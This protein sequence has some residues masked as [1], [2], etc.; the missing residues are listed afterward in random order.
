MVSERFMLSTVVFYLHTEMTLTNRRLYAKRPNTLFGI[1]P[2]GN[3]TLE[4][5]D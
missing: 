3:G 2:I 4:L 1:M 5:P